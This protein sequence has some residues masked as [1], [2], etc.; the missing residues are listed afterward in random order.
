MTHRDNTCT[1]KRRTM[2]HPDLPITFTLPT[3]R[4]CNTVT[5]DTGTLSLAAFDAIPDD[6]VVRMTDLWLS[7]QLGFEV[8][9]DDPAVVRAFEAMF[10]G[11]GI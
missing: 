10:V 2:K 3:C 11:G 1:R 6:L 7:T 8:R 5:V 9:G 4:K